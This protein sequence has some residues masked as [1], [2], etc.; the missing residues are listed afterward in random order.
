MN[1]LPMTH[2]H[3]LRYTSAR[4][5]MVL[6]TALLAVSAVPSWAQ[7]PAE[8]SDTRRVVAVIPRD[9]PPTYFLDS[10][11][12][13]AAGFA[14]DVMNVIAKPAGLQVEYVFADD[15]TSIINKVMRGEADLAL[16]LG[17]TE[18]REKYLAFT[19]PLEVFPVSF[20]VR[21]THPGLDAVPGIHTVGVIRGSVALERLKNRPDMN[22]VLYESFVQGLFD[23]LAGK[24]EA[25]A[26]PEPTLLQ[27]ARDSGVEERIKVVDRP[28]AEVKRAIAVRP[29]DRAL[30]DRLNKAI[31]GFVG[32]PAYQRVYTRW[33]GKPTPYW[34]SV[35]ILVVSVVT[36]LLMTAAM[37]A[38][39]YTSLLRLNRDLS[40]TITQWKKTEE[41]LRDSE[42]RFR[43]IFNKAN[44]GIIVTDILTKEIV[45]GNKTICSML[46]Y[47]ESELPTIRVADMHPVDTLPFILADFDRAASI[48]NSTRHNIPVKRKDRSVFYVDISASRLKFGGRFCLIGIFRDITER[49][50]AEQVLLD[51][52][53]KLRDITSTL[54]EG[55]YVLDDKANLAFMNPEAERLLGWSE[56]ELCG[57]NFHDTVHYRK[58]DGTALSLEEC[59]MHTSIRT[60]DRYTAHDEVFVRKDGTVFPIS[61]VSVPLME[62]N[63]VVSTVAAFRDISDLKQA[64]RERQDLIAQLQKALAEI[65]TLQ[66]IIPI[67]SYCK[68]IRDDEGSWTQLEAYITMHTDAMLSH[69]MCSDCAKKMYPQYYKE[70]DCRSTE[71]G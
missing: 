47:T 3:I 7:A 54:G 16:S 48:E 56:A 59:P 64:E 29:E 14:V 51:S 35:R 44:D 6:L 8:Q 38:W 5:L 20:F 1:F 66:G 13:K 11:T 57:R 50:R 28:I 70:D 46:G 9:A 39:R 55:V 19:D 63:K 60:G 26:C 61:V 41:E 65:K 21:A 37:A 2:T 67:C 68:K 24:I 27:L 36:I 18:E 31:A 58:P 40:R 4:A 62:K 23:L 10:K 22:P 53:K 15:W 12:G 32:S 42:D 43:S 69:G 25:F 71:D 45:I 17:I 52:E 33:Y 34:T 49:K 30:L